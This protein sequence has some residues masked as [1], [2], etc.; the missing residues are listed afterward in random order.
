[1]PDKFKELLKSLALG[2]KKA[3]STIKKNIEIV[4]LQYFSKKYIEINWIADEKGVCCANILFDELFSGL[5]HKTK[6]N[7]E[8]INT[9]SEYK[10]FLIS[11]ANEKISKLFKNYLNLLFNNDKRAWLE[12]DKLLKK[13]IKYW[14]SKKG[15]TNIVLYEQLYQ[16]A[17]IVFLEKLKT[18]EIN[19]KDSRLL[20]SYIFK[21]VNLKLFEFQRKNSKLLP[22]D[23]AEIER[24]PADNYDQYIPEIDKSTFVPNLFKDLNQ[25]ERNILFEVFY[26]EEKLKD[27]AKKYNISEANCRVIKHR[28]LAKLE[29]PASLYGYL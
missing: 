19:F 8:S 28:S 6:H 26:K 3:V 25:L 27:I 10:H 2:D 20:K 17:Q 4:V 22:L 16:D 13:R 12:F 29:K 7:N 18:K 15:Y 5:L 14:L 11:I 24:I 1:M 21:I 23:Y 9:F